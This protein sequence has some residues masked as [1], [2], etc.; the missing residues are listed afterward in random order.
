MF[1]KEAFIVRTA[2][3]TPHYVLR[4]GHHPT[5]LTAV[6]NASNPST[7]VIFGFSDKPQYD[8]FLSLSSKRLTPYPLVIRFLL[9]QIALHGDSLKLI[10]LDAPTPTQN[11]LSATTY[12]AVLSSLQS[13]ADHV[14][15]THQ[16]WL[17]AATAEYKIKTLEEDT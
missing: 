4:E 1:A 16:I 11:I 14:T 9:D 15:V 5:A 7:T 8:A 17:D 10:V 13:N 12:Q 3:K 6:N 2:S